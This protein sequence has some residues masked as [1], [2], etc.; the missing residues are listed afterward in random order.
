VTPCSRL[1]ALLC[2]LPVGLAA[3]TSPASA[4][5]ITM[6]EEPHHHLALQNGFVKVFEVYLAPRDAFLMHRHDTDDVAIILG[7]ATTVSTTPGKA[8][9][10]T[11]S[12]AG[13]VRF[14]RSGRIHSVRN[15]GP[16]DY[17]MV[18]IDLL[19]PQTGARNLCGTQIPDGKPACPSSAPAGSNSSHTDVPQFE[20]NQ[21]RV[22]LTSIHPHQLASFGDANLDELIIPIDQAM[23]AAV[24]GIGP[25]RSLAAGDPVWIDRGGA[26]RTV[27]N[28]GDKELRVVL[29]AFKP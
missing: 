8:D 18:S 16:M 15:I 22:T 27:K 3:Q 7:D 23:I 29:I 25:D 5:V 21:I 19:R 4:P 26:R 20:T 17:R 13:E 11:M 28:Q 12:K 24:A 6:D 9:V 2:L 14:A 1:V 10:L